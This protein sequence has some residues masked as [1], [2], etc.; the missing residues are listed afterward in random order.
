MLE[1][2]SN[3]GGG[4]CG[5]GEREVLIFVWLSEFLI[6]ERT[7]GGAKANWVRWFCSLKGEKKMKERTT[8]NRGNNSAEMEHLEHSMASI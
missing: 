2:S 5:E 6:V 4:G 7:K 3:G 1:R 8:K